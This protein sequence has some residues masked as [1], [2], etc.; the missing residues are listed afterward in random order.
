MHIRGECPN[1]TLYTLELMLLLFI[2]YG[3]FHVRKKNDIA[4]GRKWEGKQGR[5]SGD[6]MRCHGVPVFKTN[7]CDT[8]HYMELT[9]STCNVS[10]TEKTNM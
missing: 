6:V 7:C 1:P 5:V 4:S 9:I 8:A 3:Q 2:I 10:V